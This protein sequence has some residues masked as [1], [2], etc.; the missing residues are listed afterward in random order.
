[1]SSSTSVSVIFDRSP[2]NV[3]SVPHTPWKATTRRPSN[4]SLA[5]TEPLIVKTTIRTLQW[6]VS[7]G[8][9]IARF[10]KKFMA[11]L[12]SRLQLQLLLGIRGPS[13]SNLRLFFLIIIGVASDGGCYLKRQRVGKY[14][15]LNPALWRSW[16]CNV[17]T[18]Q[19]HGRW[20]RPM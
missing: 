3:K 7:L 13:S 17:H 14:T 20:T 18:I 10:S 6:G 16:K 8:C 19:V 15:S 11:N 9:R 5:K 2:S 1:M 4:A 12:S